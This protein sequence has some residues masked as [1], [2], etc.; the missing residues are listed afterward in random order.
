MFYCNVLEIAE[1]PE[2]VHYVDPHKEIFK[3]TEMRTA[4]CENLQNISKATNLFLQLF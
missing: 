4:L 3:I 1:Q 2:L